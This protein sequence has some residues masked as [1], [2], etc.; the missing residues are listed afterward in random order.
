MLHRLLT[1]KKSLNEQLSIGAINQPDIFTI[2]LRFR[3]FKYAFSA[4]IEKMYRQIWIDNV[5]TDFLRIVWRNNTSE[6]M[7]NYRLKTVTYGTASVPFLATRT[8]EQ[9]AK[10]LLNKYPRASEIIMKNMYMDDVKSGGNTETNLIETF[11]ELR[12]TFSSAGFNLRKW[13][14]NSP[15]LLKIIPKC[16]RELRA[17][18]SNVK[19]LG[20]SWSPINDE[21]SFEFGIEQ[22][23]RLEFQDWN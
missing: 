18:I 19:T 7:R 2:I 21:F 20:I 11:H 13:C 17:E 1:I 3:L 4:D 8:L 6:P 16:D 10:D 9:L 23:T 22:N 15:E 14:T 5:Q 12:N